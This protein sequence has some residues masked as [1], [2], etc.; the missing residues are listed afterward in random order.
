MHILRAEGSGQARVLV[1]DDDPRILSAI[2]SVVRRA[3]YEVQT[4]TDVAQGLMAAEACAFDAAI[5]DYNLADDTGLAVLWRLRNLQPDCAR[6]LCTGRDDL[7]AFLDAVNQ[8]EVSKIVRKP[9][10][11]PELLSHLN[12]AVQTR[13]RRGRLGTGQSAEVALAERR[14]IEELL[15]GELLKMAIQPIVHRDSTDVARFYEC[16]MRPQ[17]AL[18]SNPMELLGAGERHGE[19]VSVSNLA[20][21][22]ALMVLDKIPDEVGLF[23]NLHPAQLGQT[24]ELMHRLR[25]VQD[26]AHRI[27]LEITERSRLHDI[28]GWDESIRLAGEMGFGIAVDDLG[29]GYS[30]LAILADLRPQFIKLDMSLVRNIDAEPRKQRLVQLMVTFGDATDAG[31]IAEGVETAEEEAA[32]R[33]C[34]IQLFQGYFFGRPTI[35]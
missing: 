15:Q 21:D 7:S 3:G 5:V 19:I 4:A 29:A 14:A 28:D 23:V 35:P 1:V 9:F 6:I 32:L 30:S 8:G 22:K 24:E 34:G 13:R 33:D 18:L 10:R 17:H 12:E 16:L 25:R 31:V 2:S 27:V 11:V 20:L 26:Q